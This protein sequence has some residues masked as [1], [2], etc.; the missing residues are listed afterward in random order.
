MGIR[1][2]TGAAL[3]AVLSFSTG[4]PAFAHAQ[5]RSAT[6]ASGSTLATAPAEVV[7]NFSE[8]LEPAFSSLVVS[9]A[10]GKRVDKA[11][12]HLDQGDKTTMRV[13]LPPLGQGAYIVHWRAVTADTHRVDGSFTF[14]VG[15]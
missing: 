9:D 11:D 13:S 1:N 8:T 5:L 3:A 7:V 15:Q 4:A 10:N 14:R 12:T 6:P 2:C